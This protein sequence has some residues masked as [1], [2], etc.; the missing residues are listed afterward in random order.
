MRADVIGVVP[1]PHTFFG[2]SSHFW[3][4]FAEIVWCDLSALWLLQPPCTAEGHSGGVYRI[5]TTQLIARG[6][7]GVIRVLSTH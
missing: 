7:F 5:C 3:Q 6:R 2:A 4:D 1:D